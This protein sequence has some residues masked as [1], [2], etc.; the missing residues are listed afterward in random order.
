MGLEADFTCI[1]RDFV[2]FLEALNEVKLPSNLENIRE[3]LLRRSKVTLLNLA[4]GPPSSPEPYLDMNAGKGLLL[5]TKQETQLQEYINTELDSEPK[6]NQDYYETFQE[7]NNP[8][9]ENFPS[10]EDEAGNSLENTLTTIYF[11]FSAT[12]TRIN[13]NKW[14][15]LSRKSEIKIPFIDSLRPCWIG[16]LGSYLLIYGSEKD[17]RPNAVVPIRGYRGR[18]APSVDSKRSDSAFEIFCPGHKTLQFVAK[19]PEEMEEW[20]AIICETS[21]RENDNKT[22]LRG[23]SFTETAQLEQKERKSSESSLKDEKYQDADFRPSSLSRENLLSLRIKSVEKEAN[24]DIH[25]R[26]KTT[27]LLNQEQNDDKTPPLPARIPRR[28]PS[29]PHEDVIPS[30]P[31]IDEPYDEDDIYHKIEDFRDGTAYQ[32]FMVAKKEDEKKQQELKRNGC[33]DTYDDVATE[34]K[35]TDNDKRREEIQ[36]AYDDVQMPQKSTL[37]ENEAIVDSPELCD[38]AK[39]NAADQK[40]K[41]LSGAAQIKASKK[42]FLDRMRNRSYI[43]KKENK[44]KKRSLSPASSISSEALPTYDDIATI[45][46]NHPESDVTSEQCEYLS[47][48]VPRP[49]YSI[50]PSVTPCS[51]EQL[52]DDIAVC[53]EKSAKEPES[54]KSNSSNSFETEIS[55]VDLN[56]LT[57]SSKTPNNNEMEFDYYQSPKSNRVLQVDD[58]LYDDV[59]L[60]M[61][62]RAKQRESTVSNF[63]KVWS[64]FSSGRSKNSVNEPDDNNGEARVN[65]LQK[66]VNKIE[67]TLSKSSMKPLPLSNNSKSQSSTSVT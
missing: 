67:N 64:R 18:P 36:E 1:L 46:M 4:I 39:M 55:K 7:I 9:S 66:I 45:V 60:L 40:E 25:L 10:I 13:C 33:P 42:S 59:A 48:P 17:S 58:A 22:R 44:N 23:S 54:T 12:Q 34:I 6:V 37:P 15:Q 5:A 63:E 11:G 49:I 27:K 30:F 52:Y 62:F 14:G 41:K 2:Q 29:L 21:A 47:P 61:K 35:H 57:N 51:L 56:F 50:P 19:T 43:V 16:L 38:D 32:N 20:V 28:L 24:S 26:E 3:N 31:I 53:Q 8:K 65:R